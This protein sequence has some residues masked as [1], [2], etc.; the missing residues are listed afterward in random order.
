MTIIIDMIAADPNIDPAL[1]RI[2]S[3]QQQ[4]PVPVR[5]GRNPGEHEVMPTP[6]A[7]FKYAHDDDGEEPPDRGW[8]WDQYGNWCKAP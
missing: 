3:S 1:R 6:A 4:E 7:V 2:L 5:I 8:T